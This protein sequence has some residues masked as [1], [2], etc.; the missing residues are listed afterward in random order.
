MK[1]DQAV[2]T[3]IAAVGATLRVELDVQAVQ[4]ESPPAV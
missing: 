2:R 1:Y 4:G 3:G